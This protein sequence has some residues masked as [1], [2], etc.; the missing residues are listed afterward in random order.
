[1]CVVVFLSRWKLAE[2]CAVLTKIPVFCSNRKWF[3]PT[4]AF[5]K[6]K[7]IKVPN[8]ISCEVVKLSI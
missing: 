7:L 4:N 8:V 6:V 2:S 5:M 1:M 3:S